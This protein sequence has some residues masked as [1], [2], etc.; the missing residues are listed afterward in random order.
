MAW[1]LTNNRFGESVSAQSSKLV[2][3]AIER[4]RSNQGVSTPL[5]GLALTLTFSRVLPPWV[6]PLSIA[7]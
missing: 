6:K 1:W 2:R 7:A 3:A 4:G 5:V